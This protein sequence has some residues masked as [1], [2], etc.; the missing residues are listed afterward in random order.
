MI[1]T[2]RGKTE[3]GEG[4]DSLEGAVEEHLKLG[5][6][7]ELHHEPL[8]GRLAEGRP[9]LASLGVPLSGHAQAPD[10]AAADRWDGDSERWTRRG[11]TKTLLYEEKDDKANK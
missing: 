5:L 2:L 11:G 9:A 1:Q 10:V 4:T 8:V 3:D 7:D 6:G